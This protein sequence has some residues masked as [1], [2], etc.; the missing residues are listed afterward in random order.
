MAA[1]LKLVP[2]SSPYREFGE[3][4]IDAGYPA[5]PVARGEKFPGTFVSNEWKPT[6]DWTRF[7]DRLPTTIEV[8]FWNA[9]PDAGVCVALGYKGLVAIDIDTD[10]AEIMAAI[11]RTI[12]DSPVGKKGAKGKTLFYRCN[13]DDS[14]TR[15]AVKSRPFDVK[16][17]RVLDL[18]AHGKETVLPP[19]IHPNGRPYHW[20]GTETLVDVPVEHL[21]LLPDNIAELLAVALE[22]FGYTEPVVREYT[23]TEGGDSYW[24]DLNQAALA[25]LGMWVKDLGLPKTRKTGGGYR[26]VAVWRGVENPNLSFHPEGIKDFGND[27]RYTPIDVVMQAKGFDLNEA[28]EWLA[29]KLGMKAANDNVADKLCAKADKTAVEVDDDGPTVTLTSDT[30]LS[31]LTNPGG[32]VSDIVDWIVSSSSLPSRELALSATLPFVGALIGRRFASPTDLRTNFYSVAL[33]SSG[34]GKDHARTQLKRLVTAAGLDRFTG[35]NRFMS[36]SALRN[37]VMAKPSSVCMVDEF[38]GMM[39]Q[40]NDKKASIH[41]V[42][43][44]SD[45]LEM[46]TSASTFFEG[47]SY[48]KESAQ[49]IHNPNL[50]LYGTSTPEDFW[51]SVSSLNTVDGLLPRFLLFNVTGKRPDREDT[52]NNVYNVPQSLIDAVQALAL[53]ARKNGNLTNTDN[54]SMAIKP[55]I[56]SYSADAATELARFETFVEEAV[57]APE[58]APILNRAVE[59]AIKLALTVSVATN[60]VDPVITGHA[61]SW[62]VKLAWLSTCTMIEETGD[63]ISDNQREA[64]MK[65]ILGHIKRAGKDGITEGRIANRC[66]GIDKKRRTELLDDLVLA[67]RIEVREIPGKGR[68]KK[69]FYL[70]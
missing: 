20:L 57:S 47:A 9:W 48:A 17:E 56:V 49:K 50:C 10:D 23:Q 12:P 60:H 26:A 34:Y 40:I 30:A 33:A 53:A 6:F 19:S 16:G 55:A 7:C 59:H 1:L 37:S 58:S 32:V 3:R 45:L 43:I 28:T 68:A 61:M 22:P 62:A 15:C 14:E 66:A 8:E 42:L 54:G 64:D 44:R 21:P 65:R 25:N 5:I 51:A 70:L 11:L 24:R 52:G 13:V 2:E 4:Y 41:S 35:P 31:D 27:D 63:R 29:E 67:G 46:F 69:R 39:R 18:L 36:A 38:G